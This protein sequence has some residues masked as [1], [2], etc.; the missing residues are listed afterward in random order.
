MSKQGRFISDR[1]LIAFKFSPER[2]EIARNDPEMWI[3]EEV[4][5]LDTKTP[6]KCY[7]GSLDAAAKVLGPAPDD[8]PMT[9]EWRVISRWDL[10]VKPWR[11]RK[12]TAAQ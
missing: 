10:V 5:K 2:L 4:S 9:E 11:A 7:D 8:Y 3:K 1:T 12:L 6:G